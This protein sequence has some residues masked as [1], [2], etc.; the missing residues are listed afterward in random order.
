[1]ITNKDEIHDLN[2]D[3][4]NHYN[5]DLTDNMYNSINHNNVDQKQTTHTS[6]Y[7]LADHKLQLSSEL[8]DFD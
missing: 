5:N 2:A 8:E 4:R 3:I 6:L 7:T 1:M